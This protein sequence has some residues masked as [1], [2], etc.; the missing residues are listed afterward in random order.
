MYIDAK[1]PDAPPSPPGG[2]DVPKSPPAPPTPTDEPP[3]KPVDDPPPEAEPKPPYTVGGMCWRRRNGS[4]SK[5]QNEYPQRTTDLAHEE[6]IDLQPEKPMSGRSGPAIRRDLLRAMEDDPRAPAR[7]ASTYRRTRECRT[8]SRA[9][10]SG[11][12]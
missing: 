10:R 11:H 6:I 4:G 5:E 9:S 7:L 3:P 12:R 1:I 8:D 2:P